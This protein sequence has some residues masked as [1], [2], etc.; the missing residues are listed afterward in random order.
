[1]VLLGQNVVLRHAIKWTKLEIYKLTNG[2]TVQKMSCFFRVA[3][4]L[5]FFLLFPLL[6]VTDF[7]SDDVV[8]NNGETKRCFSYSPSPG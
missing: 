3:P 8:D 2:N 1:M 6:T 5:I 7:E 4:A